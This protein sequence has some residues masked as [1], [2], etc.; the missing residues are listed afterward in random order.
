MLGTVDYLAPELLRGSSASPLSDI[1]AL[2][3]VIYEALAGRAPFGGKSVF[4]VGMAV[5]DAVPPDPCAGRSD[6]PAHLSSTVL[7]ALAKDPAA[8]PQTAIAYANLLTVAVRST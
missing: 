6:A 8:R 4:E 1:Y 7:L 3:C 2:G 5:L